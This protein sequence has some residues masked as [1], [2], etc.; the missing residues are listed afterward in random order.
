MVLSIT[1]RCVHPQRP[2]L[3]DI[4]DRKC[5]RLKRPSSDSRKWD[6]KESIKWR[7][8]IWLKALALGH[9]DSLSFVIQQDAKN[10]KNKKAFKWIFVRREKDYECFYW[11]NKNEGL[12]QCSFVVFVL[13]R[14]QKM[15]DYEWRF[16]LRDNEQRKSFS[17]KERIFLSFSAN[18]ICLSG[19]TWLYYI[20]LI[21]VVESYPIVS[22]SAPRLL[23]VCWPKS[24]EQI[25][26]WNIEWWNFQLDSRCRSNLFDVGF[27]MR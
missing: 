17:A 12:L 10:K 1:C 3:V 4:I 13:S 25:R 15:E 7:F 21:E 24:I 9:P 26:K 19:E 5:S 16:Y 8:W 18:A 23:H 22:L 27:D 20:K 2:L 6:F 14:P 11:F